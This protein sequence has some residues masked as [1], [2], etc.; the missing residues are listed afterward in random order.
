MGQRWFLFVRQFSRQ[1]LLASLLCALSTAPAVAQESQ[2]DSPYVWPQMI[3]YKRSATPGVTRFSKV[4]DDG[5]QKWGLVDAAGKEVLP[6][7]YDKISPNGDGIFLVVADENDPNTCKCWFFNEKTGKLSARSFK[8]DEQLFEANEGLIGFRKQDTP[9]F[10]GIH[11]R[12]YYNYQHEVVIPEQYQEGSEFRDGLAMVSPEIRAT[13]KPFRWQFIDKKGKI[14]A[15]EIFPVSLFYNGLAIASP[16][17]IPSAVANSNDSDGPAN[18]QVVSA[19]PQRKYGL[20]NRQFQFVVKPVYTSLQ[21]VAKNV[22]AARLSELDDYIAIE[23]TGRKLFDFSPGI[24]QFRL[25]DENSDDLIVAGLAVAKKDPSS[26]QL[27]LD[28]VFDLSGKMIV[29]PKYKVGTIENGK[30]QLYENT[31]F[32]D[33]AYGVMNLKGEWIEPMAYPSRRFDSAIWKSCKSTYQRLDQF[34]YFLQDYDLIGMPRSAVEKLLG[35]GSSSSLGNQV[36]F[37]L[38]MQ[39]GCGNSRTGIVIDYYDGRVKRWRIYQGM[40]HT[41]DTWF[42]DNMIFRP[43]VEPTNDFVQKTM[44]GKL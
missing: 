22:F 15:P 1:I 35:A 8:Y 30:I 14:V 20:V 34:A 9:D 10:R 29:P 44:Y 32:H 6:A 23:E 7:K 5:K 37:P 26:P 27:H 28:V 16:L 43:N 38:N 21:R 19:L 24:T 17:A 11:S 18:S 40:E 33:R 41:A 3:I 4:A 2:P 42:T 12:G 31:Y 13:N 39:I 36:C 25:F